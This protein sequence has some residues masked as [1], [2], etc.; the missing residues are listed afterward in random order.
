ML[1]IDSLVSH[2]PPPPAEPAAPL[3][4]LIREGCN[5][6]CPLCGSTVTYRY[7]LFGHKRCIHPDCNYGK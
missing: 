2:V 7:W 3:N 4:A 5:H 6:A 1:S